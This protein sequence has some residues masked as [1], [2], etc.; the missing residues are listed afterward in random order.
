MLATLFHDRDIK[1]TCHDII[2]YDYLTGDGGCGQAQSFV[3][4][5]W[6]DPSEEK[7]GVYLPTSLVKNISQDL[8]G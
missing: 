3:K 8:W 5:R 4:S 6:D 2:M 7:L 1:H